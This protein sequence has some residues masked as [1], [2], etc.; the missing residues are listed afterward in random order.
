MVIGRMPVVPGAILRAR[1]IGVLMM[2]DEA[3]Q[4]EKILAVPIDKIT[5][6]HRNVQSYKDVPP[7]DLARITHFFEHYKDLEPNKWVKVLGWEDAD[8][9]QRLI[10]E[11]IARVSAPSA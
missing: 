6:V 9:A 3:G 2:E 5:Q 7:I 11:G 1:P 10:L 4:D 8:V